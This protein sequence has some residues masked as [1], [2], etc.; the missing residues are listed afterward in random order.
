MTP[1][2]KLIAL[3]VVEIERATEAMAAGG[4][5]KA[6]RREMERIITT[7]T[8][9]AYIAAAAQRLGVPPDSAL[10]SR[11]RLSRA[12]RADIQ[13]QV[14]DQL[15]FLD[16]FQAAMGDMSP[17]AI[18]AR[19]KLY[20]T[21]PRA[22][23]SAQRWLD[24]DIPDGLLPGR[25]QCGGRCYCVISVS[26]NGDGTGTLTRKMG[27][28]ESDHCTECPPLAGDHPVKRRRAA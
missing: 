13:A 6:W 25:Q 20:A 23:Y 17:A 10:L 15:R 21:G 3:A 5:T 28:P 1:L 22:F 2:D 12:E 14:R 26:D 19:A 18:L 16:G 11:A 8:T 9:A 24:W 4:S 27:A 7:Q